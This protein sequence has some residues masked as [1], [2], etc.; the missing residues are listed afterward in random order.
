MFLTKEFIKSLYGRNY[1]RS[2]NDGHKKIIK[3]VR[4]NHVLKKIMKFASSFEP[5]SPADLLEGIQSIIPL[6]PSSSSQSARAINRIP[7]RW[8]ASIKFRQSPAEHK[9]F[10]ESALVILSLLQGNQPLFALTP[11]AKH[12][13]KPTTS[14]LLSAA[15]E[16]LG[17][18]HRDVKIE[19]DLIG[20]R[21]SGRGVAWRG[22]GQCNSVMSSSSPRAIPIWL[23]PV[24]IDF[25]PFRFLEA[26]HDGLGQEEIGRYRT[27]KSNN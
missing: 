23:S 7:L 16:A 8:L 19:H 11:R 17:S 9:Y 26:R 2:S 25:Y 12:N 13:T 22:S 5:S 3:L 4:N 1:L 20:S 15:F 10:F 24:R 18:S 27:K 21:A 6:G 14:P